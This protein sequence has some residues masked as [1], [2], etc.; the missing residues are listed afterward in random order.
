MKIIRWLDA[1]LEE[2][3]LAI[4][5]VLIVCVSMMQVVI[6]KVPWIPALTWAEEFCRFCWV[7][8][9]FLSLPYTL[10]TGSMLRV[11]VLL[12][13]LPEKVMKV[14]NIAVYVVTTLCML[15]LAYYSVI[16]VGNIYK[17]SETSPAM[18]WPM[19]TVYSIMIVGFVLAVVRGVQQ[20]IIHVLNFHGKELNT[21]EQAMMDAKLETINAMHDMLPDGAAGVKGGER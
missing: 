12:D 15:M 10:R 9:V 2:V 13:Y 5:L 17:S 16:V 11:T 21:A 3:L 6:R 8:S 7:W 19:W 18:L 20:V 14:L 1:H 4:L